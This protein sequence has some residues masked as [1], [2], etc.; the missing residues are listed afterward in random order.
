MKKSNTYMDRALKARDPRYAT[1]LGKL[2]YDRRDMVADPVSP[3]D[4][5]PQV[6]PDTEEEIL[7][8]LR[9]EYKETVG[10]HAYHAWDADTLRRKIDEARG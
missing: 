3:V 5:T 4:Q 9:A 1:I 2:G 7:L 8:R 6:R 10:R